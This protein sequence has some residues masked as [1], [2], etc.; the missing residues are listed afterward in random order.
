MP[1]KDGRLINRN[2][3]FN[4]ILRNMYTQ[5]IKIS[6]MVM[7]NVKMFRNSELNYILHACIN[8]FMLV[9]RSYIYKYYYFKIYQIKSQ[10]YIVINQ[11]IK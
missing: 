11:Y 9:T 1:I 3:P 10:W 6:G 5:W 7:T 2:L 8:G 4:N